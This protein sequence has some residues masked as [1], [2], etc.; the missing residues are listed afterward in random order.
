[1]RSLIGVQKGEKTSTSS[2]GSTTDWKAAK[3]PCIPPFKTT[4][5]CSR[6]GMRLRS[7]SFEAMAARSSGMPD[8]GA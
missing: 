2:P 1:M 3:S 6:A 5:S 4:T 7:L 8:E